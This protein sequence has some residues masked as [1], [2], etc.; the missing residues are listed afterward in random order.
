[1]GSIANNIQSFVR[2]LKEMLDGKKYQVDYFQREYKWERKHIEQLLV[3][4]EAS[5]IS[6][7]DLGHEIKDVSTYNCYYLGPVVISER[8]LA[9][10]IV[11]GQQRLTSMTLL[12]IFLNN[13]QRNRVDQEDLES[14]I[15][16]KKHGRKSYNIEVP[17][18]T[19][20]LDVLFNNHAVDGIDED[21]DESVKTMADRYN[22]IS[23]MFSE[24][25]RDGKLPLFIDWLKEKVVFVEIIA[26]T[27]E[28]A[29]TIFETMNDRGLNLTPTEM[30][31]G[32]I[33]TNVK[34]T[35]RIHE[36]NNIW[37]KQ[38]SLLHSY[39][40]QEDL[41]FFKAW[42]RGLYADTIRQSIKGA[43]NEDFEKIGTR[44]HTWIKDNAKKLNLRDSDNFYYFIKADFQFY[45]TIYTNILDASTNL[46]GVLEVIYLSSFWSIASSVSLPLLLASITPLDDEET[47]VRKIQIVS[48]FLDIFT[49]VRMINKKSITQS[50]IRYF[51]YSLAKEIRNKNTDELTVLLK[52]RLADMSE[53]INA[54]DNFNYFSSDRKFIHYLLARI[55]YYLENTIFNKE[56]V[57]DDLM[58]PRKRNRFIVAPILSGVYDDYDYLYATEGDFLDAYSAIGNFVL[59]PN[60]LSQEFYNAE[61]EGKFIVSKK[62]FVSTLCNDSINN[63]NS[64]DLARWGFKKMED[65]SQESIEERTIALKNVIKEIWSINSF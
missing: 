59:I 2:T 6:N 34:D 17:D 26:Y 4:L 18:R 22:D 9:K 7:Y 42:M 14:M 16:S 11:D 39:S 24:E 36:L 37:K 41:E 8:L 54:V 47:I 20:I 27:D 33:L 13:L 53:T 28:N 40:T 56:I 25:L 60:Q 19:K 65:L 12:L 1:M 44:F 46:D 51:L 15:Y 55:T 3:D 10:S 45:S 61:D 43:E 30:L 31:K 50:S 64:H 52:T 63:D 48:K 21:E 23:N 35:D 38:I 57:F 29:Y 62:S 49:V 58:V 5:F 32:Y